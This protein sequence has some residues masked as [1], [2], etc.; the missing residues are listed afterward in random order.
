MADRPGAGSPVIRRLPGH[1]V[2]RIAAG[3]VVE[4]PAAAL[5]ELVENALDAGARRI[6]IVLEAG[7]RDLIRVSDDGC[8]MSPEAMTLALERHATSKLPTDD[9]DAI[10]TLGFRGEALPSIA[11]VAR[12]TIASRPAGQPS[13]WLKTVDNGTLESDEPCAM[14]KGTRIEVRGLFQKV[15]ARFKFLKSERAEFA[16]CLDPVR[17]LAMARPDVS[18]SIEHQGR[19]VFSAPAGAGDAA[20]QARSRMAQVLGPD[21]AD[22][23]TPIDAARP[24][25]ALSGFVAL[26]TYNRGTP[27]QQH[28]FVNGRPVRDRQLTGAVRA[29]FDNLLARDR[30]PVVA[31]FVWADDGF[32]D[33]NVHPAKAEVRFRDAALVRGLIVSGVRQ[34]LDRAGHRAATTTASAALGAFQP[35]RSAAS[36]WPTP[37]PLQTRFALA[38]AEPAAAC[39]PGPA[40]PAP[41]PEPV[42]DTPLGQARAQLHGTYIVAETAGGLVLVDQHAA[43]ERL[44][45]E[46]MRTALAD[47]HI[48]RQPLLVPDVVELEIDAADRLEARQDELASL[49]LI[50]ERFGPAAVLVRETPAMLGVIDSR[51]LLRDLADDLASH[52]QPLAL[53]EKLEQLCST[54]ACHAS[55]RAGRRLS[56]EEMNALLRQMEATPHSGQ[57][58]HGRPT[59]VTLALTD[60][61]K[62]FGRR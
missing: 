36:G 17:R 21:F 45:Y 25:L 41:L 16:A 8:G 28:L 33:V 22:N 53:K 54:M 6:D 2:N 14:P 39:E 56:V 32:V 26:P 12:M 15:P 5:K 40:A 3:E 7:G 52:G 42:V 37:P 10:T 11:S 51:A 9:L 38:M 24:G 59:Y 50:I 48:A 44:T 55:V 20:L 31:L 57:C 18:F 4:R 46:A 47:G 27:D 29:A 23:A 19:L 1:L 34:A 30:F 13:G 58:N 61:E 43:H 49:G 62:L 35:Q 60:I